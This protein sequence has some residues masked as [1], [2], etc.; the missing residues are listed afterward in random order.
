MKKPIA[1]IG[2]AC[3]AAVS[4]ADGAPA[5]LSYAV[6]ES[7]YLAERDPSQYVEA[8]PVLSAD[9]FAVGNKRLAVLPGT[10][11]TYTEGGQ[12]VFSVD[13]RVMPELVYYTKVANMKTEPDL[14]HGVVRRT[15]VSKLPP[16]KNSAAKETA[17]VFHADLVDLKD[18]RVKAVYS[19]DNGT[20][21]VRGVA[22]IYYGFAKHFAESHELEVE[23]AKRLGPGNWW[24]P[25]RLVWR[26]AGGEADLT[27]LFDTNNV[28]RIT[29]GADRT[30]LQIVC[31]DRD[32]P[33][34]VTLDPGRTLVRKGKP[35]LV[36]G[37]DF[38]EECKLNATEYK[39]SKNIMINPSFESGD[40]YYRLDSGNVI[41]NGVAH[42]GAHSL[43][44]RPRADNFKTV[45]VVLDGDKDYTFS[46]YMKSADKGQ[47]GL[48]VH[49]RGPNGFAGFLKCLK[50][51]TKAPHDEWQRVEGTFHTTADFHECAIWIGAHNAFI[52]DIQIEEGTNATAYAGNPFG[53]DLASDQPT[54]GYADS[55]KPQNLRLV[56]RGPAGASAKVGVIGTD[57]FGRPLCKKVQTVSLPES[58]STEIALG[59]DSAW[60]LGTF[61]FAVRLKSGDVDYR[62]YLRFSKIDARDGT[63]RLRFLQGTPEFGTHKSDVKVPASTYARLRDFGFGTLTYQDN[64]SST[65]ER[66]TAEDYANLE[67]YGLRDYWGGVLWS[68]GWSGG[69][70]LGEPFKIDGKHPANVTN[71]PPAFL[72]W[73]E[74]KCC[75]MAKKYPHINFW[76]LASEPDGQYE[77]L[78]KGHRE[79][80]AKLMLAINRGLKRGNPKNVY[81]PYGHWNMNPG[82]GILYEIEFL[83]VLTKLEPETHFK[84]IDVHTYRELPEHPDIESDLQLFLR[85]LDE[86]GYGDLKIKIG[87]GSYFYPVINPALRLFPW[88]GVGVKDGYSH[89]RT[90]SYDIGWGERIGAAL[91]LRESLVY[92]RHSDRVFSNTSW[93]PYDIDGHR[94][95]AWAAMNAALMKLLGDS[96][97][98]EDV[99]L[100]PES[101]AYVFDDGRGSTVA[102]VW[103]GNVR[104]DRGFGKPVEMKVRDAGRGMR[105]EGLELIDM[106]G[107]RCEAA[108]GASGTPTASSARGVADCRGTARSASR[109]TIALP[110]SGFPFYLKVKN[111]KRG[112][113]IAALKGAEVAADACLKALLP[114]ERVVKAPKFKGEVDWSKVPVTK[115]S[116]IA[117]QVAWNEE[118]LRFRALVDQFQGWGPKVAL[119]FDSFGNGRENF[120]LGA[121]G[122]DF[123]DF[124]YELRTPAGP[125]DPPP[126]CFRVRAPDHQFTGGAGH[127]FVK[128]VVESNVVVRIAGDGLKHRTREECKSYVEADF[129]LRYLMP[130]KLKAGAKFGFAA[131]LRPYDSYL[132]KPERLATVIL[133][134]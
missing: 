74:T 1:F 121:S 95:F 93:S 37:V 125:K 104:Y 83:K 15:K 96:T 58:G 99:R 35:F 109:E 63:D 107:N 81:V 101:R 88:S 38:A 110:L 59:P 92:F 34:A 39:S 111:A 20:N 61:S 71:Y 118:T 51:S 69:T 26:T 90:P 73:V 56:V 86:I 119:T 2:A 8:K 75:E 127:G 16:P 113:L 50:L 100:G 36:G 49:P 64:H 124:V 3:V 9:G 105:D 65:Y 132:E 133:E 60:P 82:W 42:S 106:M 19:V 48:S 14:A 12:Q 112:E 120:V 24:R 91:T 31:A 43:Y 18:G 17:C 89:V 7:P 55:K 46:A 122:F 68:I 79:E 13:V 77:T 102:A 130:L 114:T 27:L 72:E 103:R 98:V 134:K 11:F 28:E 116:G 80:Y 52:D 57:F 22:Q 85:R 30:C 62:D 25:S 41:T 53:L 54:V 70:L 129:P 44:M 40:R 87:E 108:R 5:A 33:I 21:E 23:S 32:R 29:I 94:T 76:S 84:A 67:K 4:L 117:W 97:F 47:R 131:E 126:H 6:P 66:L 115:D 123:D 10:V 45:A 128:D 78:K